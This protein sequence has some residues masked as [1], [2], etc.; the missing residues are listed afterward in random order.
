MEGVCTGGTTNILEKVLVKELGGMPLRESS[1]K[2]E[3][4]Q[5]C[6]NMGAFLR[7][8]YDRRYGGT[9]CGGERLK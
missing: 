9:S 7:R 8:S 3:R 2:G 6:D 5:L 4:N 1:F